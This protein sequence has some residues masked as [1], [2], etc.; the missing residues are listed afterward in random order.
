MKMKIIKRVL[1]V[2]AVGLLAFLLLTE[3]CIYTYLR[4]YGY[5]MKELPR[6]TLVY[7]HLNNGFTVKEKNGES[8][9][10][11]RNAIIYEDML[12][13]RGYKKVDQMGI[14]LFYKKGDA[15]D[16]GRRYDFNLVIGNEGCHWFRLYYLSNGYTIEELK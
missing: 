4:E 7:F 10:I 11:G 6:T 5:G 3:V 14:D 12:E 9:F 1:I 2:L 15:S 8:T 13:D 16:D